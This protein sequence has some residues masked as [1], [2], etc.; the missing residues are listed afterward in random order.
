MPEAAFKRGFQKVVGEQG[1]FKDWGGE[2]NDLL[3][4]H[5]RIKTKRIATAV[6]FKGP[7]LKGKLTPAKMGRNG[8]QIQ[9][10][11]DSEA[12]LFLLQYWDQVDESVY[13]QMRVQALAR[14][15]ARGGARVTYGVIE[16]IDSARLIEAYPKEFEKEKYQ[17]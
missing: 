6:A 15:I 5:M 2:K 13:Q 16:G 4:T 12:D 17:K 8:D 7:G 9:R 11:F 1:T 3:T 10:L 14:S